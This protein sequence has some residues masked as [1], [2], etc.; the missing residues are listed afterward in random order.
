MSYFDLKKEN[1][2]LK[3]RLDEALDEIQELEEKVKR[4]ARR[5]STSL[6]GNSYRARQMEALRM[7]LDGEWELDTHRGDVQI[8]K[9][10]KPN[11][12]AA[13]RPFKRRI[14]D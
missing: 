14:R 12:L 11:P 2:V 13:N 3:K 1:E 6:R 7:I 9:A 8:V 10:E 5:W 4:L